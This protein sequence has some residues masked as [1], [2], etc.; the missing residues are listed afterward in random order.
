MNSSL[1]YPHRNRAQFTIIGVL[2]FLP[3]LSQGDTRYRQTIPGTNI[4]DLGEPGYIVQNRG[5]RQVIQ[6]TLPGMD[7]IDLSK[8]GYVREGNELYPTL[9]GGEI[10]DYRRPGVVELPD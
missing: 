2:V 9:P 10:R 3:A 4:E 7:V 5:R 8:P 6:Q 1:S